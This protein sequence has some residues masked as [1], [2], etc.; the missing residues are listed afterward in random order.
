[1]REEKPCL[2]F[3]LSALVCMACLVG[4]TIN[5]SRAHK[6]KKIGLDTAQPGN[7]SGECGRTGYCN[8]SIGHCI[9]LP[10]WGGGRCEIPYLGACRI[11]L[12]SASAPCQGFGGAM[13]CQCRH[14][15]IALHAIFGPSKRVFN[16]GDEA[17]CWT[18][19]AHEE[20]SLSGLPRNLSS[21]RYWMK[22]RYFKNPR[23]QKELRERVTLARAASSPRFKGTST[24]STL[25]SSTSIPVWGH[26]VDHRASLRALA[27][28]S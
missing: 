14:D 27:F 1:M 25:V 3:T 23:K 19:D 9:C 26:L 10:G 13:S 22:D 4:A 20:L 21:V 11:S 8:P 5:H 28:L 16:V 2:A 17:V 7:C 18:S 12:M 6:N 15:C 24:V